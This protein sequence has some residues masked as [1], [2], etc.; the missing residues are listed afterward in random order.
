MVRSKFDARFQ[1]LII[2]AA[3]YAAPALTVLFSLAV[4]VHLGGGA[5]G[6][7][8]VGA[9]A[10][11]ELATAP[12]AAAGGGG[13]DLERAVGLGICD[14]A[15]AAVGLQPWGSA[16]AAAQAAAAGGGSGSG[17]GGAAGLEG[18]LA[19]VWAS[20][21]ALPGA[22]WSD[23]A[24]FF[25]WWACLS[26]AVTYGFGVVFWLVRPEDVSVEEIAPEDTTTKGKKDKVKGKAKAKGGGGGAKAAGKG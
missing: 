26:W 21:P 11:G 5:G 14:A 6:I 19:G 16:L 20:L 10:A 17:G 4:L 3:Q 9:A 2:A 12:A 13:A 23:A 24:G 25:A 1:Y 15:R 8:G 22:F 18:G 7:G